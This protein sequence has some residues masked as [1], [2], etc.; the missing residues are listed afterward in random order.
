MN[1]QTKIQLHP[2][3]YNQIDYNSKVLLLGSCF[4]ENIGD[5]FEYYKFITTINSLGILFH[6]LA[7]ENLIIRSINKE[8]YTEDDLYFNNEQWCCLDAHSK[9]NSTSKEDLLARLNGQIDITSEQ[10]NCGTHYT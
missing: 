2:E 10:I 7:I 1:L 5:K 8:Y 3:K 4:S 6:P 9:L